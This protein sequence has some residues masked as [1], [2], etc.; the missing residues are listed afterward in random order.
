MKQKL[1]TLAMILVVHVGSFASDPFSPRIYQR[2]KTLSLDAPTSKSAGQEIA[3]WPATEGSAGGGR[4][5]P[6]TDINRDNVGSLKIAWVYRHGDYRSGGIFPDKN[7]KGTAFESTPIVVEDRLIFTTPF[8][9]AIALDPETGAE[10]W[11][12]DPR[13]DKDRRFGNMMINRGVAYWNGR[14]DH[15][16]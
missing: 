15:G 10:L 13:I 6:L 1:F 7:F 16:A 12:F 9:R 14:D 8:D 11:T 3:G 4:Y 5:S 2:G